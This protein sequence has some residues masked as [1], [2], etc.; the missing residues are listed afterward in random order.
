MLHYYYWKIGI[1]CFIEE[2]LDVIFKINCPMEGQQKEIQYPGWDKDTTG[3]GLWNGKDNEV[4][5]GDRDVWGNIEMTGDEEA[6][7][8]VL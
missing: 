8:N 2:I 1:N 6:V 5:W 3:K 7:K 4:P